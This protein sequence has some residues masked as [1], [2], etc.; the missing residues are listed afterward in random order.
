MEGE[1]SEHS[2]LLTYKGLTFAPFLCYEGILP[3]HVREVC[4]GKRPDVLISLTND[5]WFGDSWEPYQHL[6]F[7]RFRAVEHRSPLVRATNTGISAFVSITGDVA[8]DDR[9]GL[10]Q[11]GVLVK[12]VPILKRGPTIYV[13]FGHWFP[14]LAGIIVLLGLFS[15]L[16]RPPPLTEQ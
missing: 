16:M 8:S 13:R 9:L 10:F 5:S 4:A 1:G 14:T 12:D 7:T 11:E 2:T 3:D 6:N 15:A